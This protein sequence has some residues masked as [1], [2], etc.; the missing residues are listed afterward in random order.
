MKKM[1]SVLVILLF[2]LLAAVAMAK[3]FFFIYNIEFNY[4]SLETFR[5]LFKRACLCEFE[6]IL[7]AVISVLSVIFII[8]KQKESIILQIISGAL[9]TV[10][11]NKTYFMLLRGIEIVN[12]AF[13]QKQLGIGIE[14]IQ[15]DYNMELRSMLIAFPIL[16]SVSLIRNI[17]GI[18]LLKGTFMKTFIDCPAVFLLFSEAIANIIFAVFSVIVLKRDFTLVENILT[19]LSTGLLAAGTG[20]MILH[21][22]NLEEREGGLIPGITGFI[23]KDSDLYQ[24]FE[25]WILEDDDEEPSEETNT[26][27]NTEGEDQI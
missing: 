12:I 23:R 27:E 15:I 9:F 25:R 13:S 7:M 5:F 14:D 1:L 18:K 22:N 21:R 4:S 6:D 11:V 8:R 17:L 2:T 19:Y 16:V 10:I 3:H 24:S 20:M 26:E